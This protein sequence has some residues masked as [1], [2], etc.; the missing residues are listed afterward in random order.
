MSKSPG[1]AEAPLGLQY[2]PPHR[3]FDAGPSFRERPAVL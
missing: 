2:P 3:L 1:R